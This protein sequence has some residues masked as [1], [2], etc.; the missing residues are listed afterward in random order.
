MAPR[1]FAL[2]GDPVVHSLSPAM[3]AAAFAALGYSHTYEALLTARGELVARLGQLRSGYFSGLNVTV[4]HKLTTFRQIDEVD[5]SARA[6]GA[7]NTLELT[8]AGRL[9]GTNTDMGGLTRELRTLAQPSDSFVGRSAVVLGGGGAALAAL[10]SLSELGFSHVVV[11]LRNV[12]QTGD[13]ARA[14]LEHAFASGTGPRASE[15]TLTF[16]DLE[17]CEVPPGVAVV[18]QA[19]SCGM[20]RGSPGEIVADAIP[21]KTLPPSTLAVDVVY[22]PRPTPFV[23]RAR[24][25]GLRAIDGRGM[26]V[27]QGA[28][29]LE[30]WLGVAA[31]REA[32]RAAV[33]AA[34]EGHGQ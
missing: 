28:L 27:E 11:C 13:E 16:C 34:L 23:A 4:P 24:A 14:S 10:A 9:R 15:R 3:H 33:E 21:W 2:V 12:T 30:R 8:S 25:H 19:T 20:R 31:P 18:V 22:G 1:R 32:M 6:V 5:E 7:V 29:A 26:L 17:A